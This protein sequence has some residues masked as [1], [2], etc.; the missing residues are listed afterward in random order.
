MDSS[1]DSSRLAH[2]DRASVLIGAVCLVCSVATIA[3]GLRLYTRSRMLKQL[4]I[5][6]YLVLMAWV[7]YG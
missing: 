2:D 7:S 4:G 3:V 6:D 1:V 5:D